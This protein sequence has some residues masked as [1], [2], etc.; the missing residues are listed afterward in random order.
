MSY[1]AI[2]WAMSQ[3]V[4]KASAKFVLVAMADCVNAEG[5][6][7]VC[8]PSQAHLVRITHLDIKTVEASQRFLREQGF[9]VD[10]EQRRGETSR[11]RVYRL[12]TTKSGGVPS[13]PQGNQGGVEPPLNTPENGGIDASS[14]APVFPANTTVFPGQSPQISREIP[15]KTG[16]GTRNGTRNGTKKEPGSGE[17]APSIPGVPAELLTDWLA[18]R[19]AKKAGPL[20]ATA[21]GGLVR[22][23]TKAGITPAEAV[24]FCCEA[25]WQGFNAGWYADRTKG[26]TPAPSS[27]K[28]SG[29]AAK[30]YREGV[31]AD[32]SFH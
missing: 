16:D 14:N 3:P 11:V 26:K 9:I 20:T 27:G 30:N 4:S 31:E 21:I 5:A 15:P 19:K 28:H 8:W 10:T 29:F 24:T 22:E 17:H 2:R 18:V 23:A 13:G 25:G 12:N 6:D 32:G 1:E 7:M